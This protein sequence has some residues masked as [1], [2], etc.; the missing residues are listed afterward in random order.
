[1]AAAQSRRLTQQPQRPTAARGSIPEQSDKN[2][3]I[4][5]PARTIDKDS[6]NVFQYEAKSCPDRPTQHRADKDNPN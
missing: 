6:A 4:P 1:M 5:S 2:A 3:A